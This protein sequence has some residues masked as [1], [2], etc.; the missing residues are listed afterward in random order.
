MT[1]TATATATAISLAPYT[2]TNFKIYVGGNDQEGSYITDQQ[3]NAP[4]GSAVLGAA[5]SKDIA[6]GDTFSLDGNGNLVLVSGKIVPAGYIAV[7]G[8]VIGTK[9]VS[10]TAPGTAKTF[11]VTCTSSLTLS[12]TCPL[13]CTGALSGSSASYI[14]S[15]FWWEIGDG[16]DNYFTPYAVSV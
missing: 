5:D 6:D 11:K 9:D 3:Q 10:L 14:D 2:L 1:E 12:G 7:Q 13:T 4:A 16:A 8:Q 15:G